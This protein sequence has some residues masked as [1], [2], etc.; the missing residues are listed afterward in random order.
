MAVIVIVVLLGLGAVLDGMLR[1]FLWVAAV[2]VA[3]IALYNEL[4]KK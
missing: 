3:V 4:M 2:A 1:K